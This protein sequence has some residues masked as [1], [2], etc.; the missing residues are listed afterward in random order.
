LLLRKLVA[1]LLHYIT[2][3]TIVQREGCIFLTWIDDVLIII[4]IIII[5]LPIKP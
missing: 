4:I 3:A 1:S 5:M 2:R